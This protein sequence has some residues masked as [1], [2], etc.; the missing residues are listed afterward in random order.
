MTDV[1][2][3]NEPPPYPGQQPIPE[4]QPYQGQGQQYP[5]PAPQPAYS[6]GFKPKHPQATTVLVL[7]IV[8]LVAVFVCCLP[9]GIAPWIMGNKGVKEI[10][11]NPEQWDGRSELQTGK[12]LGIVAMVIF[13]LGLLAF[14]AIFAFIGIGAFT[15]PNF[16]DDL[17]SDLDTYSSIISVFAR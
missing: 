4:P 10:D 8:S 15:D 16:F 17:D 11:A 14:V 3:G 9:L 5:P 2:P 1:P 6:G 7:G 12:I 13:G